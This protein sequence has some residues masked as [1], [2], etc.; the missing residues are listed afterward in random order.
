MTGPAYDSEYFRLRAEWLRYR[1]HL[2]DAGTSLPT[3]AWALEDARRLVEQRGVI[4]M[5][6]MDLGADRRFERQRGWGLYDQCV[7]AFSEALGSL[8]AEAMIGVDDTVATIGVRSDKFVVFLAG[9]EAAPLTEDTLAVL[10]GAIA[11][12]LTEILA[13]RLPAEL[14][15][16]TGFQF[17]TALLR[18]DPMLRPERSIHRGLDLA[19]SRSLEQWDSERDLHT[20]E[21]ARLIEKAEI[22]TFTQPIFDLVEMG[23]LGQ[24]VF[25]RGRPGTAF[26]DP[27]HL[28]D[29]AERTGNLIELERLCRRRGLQ[30]LASRLEPGE[31]L[32]LNTTGRSLTDDEV[33]GVGFVRLVEKHGLAPENIVIEIAERFTLEEREAVRRSVADLKS[34]GFQIAIDDMGAGHSSLQSI[35][36]LEPDY[37]KFDI[38]LV[39]N[40]HR[41]VIKRSLLETLM[42]FSAKIGARVVAEGIEEESELETVRAIGVT[43]GQGHHLAAPQR[44]GD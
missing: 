9:A 11:D 24:E 37:L 39:R 26:E 40:I 35:V 18:R 27:E 20:S 25:S 34:A 5:L 42:E 10:A 38:A 44:L 28:F 29:L 31:K 43:L 6:F 32:F 7:L 33:A 4:G 23:R 3:L 17:G 41:S 2:F 15:H 14:G 16:A 21:L 13:E 12:R 36:D 30:A 19:M 1:G 22:V 8:R